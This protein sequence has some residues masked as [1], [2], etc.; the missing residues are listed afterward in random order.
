MG[1]EDRLVEEARGALGDA[2]LAVSGR[3]VE[4]DRAAGA[5]GRSEPFDQRLGKHQPLQALDE[6]VARHV[7]EMDRLR[8]DARAER[9]ERHR[10]RPDILRLAERR[11]G[12]VQALGGQRV[13]DVG[14]HVVFPRQPS[15]LHVGERRQLLD[16]H[17]DQ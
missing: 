9:L 1:Q 6:P 5:E 7:L 8:E 3:P 10:R 15:R 13:A 17:I 12:V 4:K 11:P 2:R 14:A 16:R